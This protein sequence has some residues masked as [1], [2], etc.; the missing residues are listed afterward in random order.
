MRPL[1]SVS[2]ARKTIGRNA[3]SKASSSARSSTRCERSSMRALEAGGGDVAPCLGHRR[4]RG[5][6]ADDAQL[7]EVVGEP[8]RDG[9]DAGADVERRAARP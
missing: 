9:R 5:L 8:G 6:E 2:V 7:G 4:R 3:K 1:R